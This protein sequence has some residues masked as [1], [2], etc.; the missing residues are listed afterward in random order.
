MRK[1]WLLWTRLT[2]S[3]VDSP[4]QTH[5]RVR[6]TERSRTKL[7]TKEPHPRKTS[8]SRYGVHP[9]SEVKASTRHLRQTGA[10]IGAAKKPDPISAKHH[11]CGNS[12]A[13]RLNAGVTGEALSQ[14]RTGS[15]QER[16][17]QSSQNAPSEPNPAPAPDCLRLVAG[18]TIPFAHR[19]CGPGDWSLRRGPSDRVRRVARLEDLQLANTS[20]GRGHVEAP[21]EA[22]TERPARHVHCP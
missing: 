14:A 22:P 8:W 2:P 21:L 9:E 20:G 11:A 16:T 13:W 3:P 10:G 15:N 17:R 7:G 6:S 18:R 12:A 4:R 5:G 1:D 19:S